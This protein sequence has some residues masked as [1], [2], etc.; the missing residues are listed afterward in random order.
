MSA[1]YSAGQSCLLLV[2]R[3]LRVNSSRVI[4]FLT[5]G[6]DSLSSCTLRPAQS[7]RAAQSPQHSS[8]SLRLRPRLAAVQVRVEHD[9]AVAED[10]RG[11]S[12]RSDAGGETDVR[13]VVARGKRL[14]APAFRRDTAAQATR[15]GGAERDRA[16]MG[17]HRPGAGASGL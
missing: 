4:F 11:V 2:P 9:S 7:L 10:A 5:C 3:L 12:I 1:R 14:H 13:L 15:R 17:G 16:G 8:V 6:H